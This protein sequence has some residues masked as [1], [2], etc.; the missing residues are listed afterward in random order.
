MVVA[1]LLTTLFAAFASCGWAAGAEYVEGEALVILKNSSGKRL[2]ARG[3]RGDAGFESTLRAVGRAGARTAH[4]YGDLSETA[5]EV[6]ALVRSETDSTE[7]LIEKLSGDPDV[8]SVTPNYI[9]HTKITPSDPLYTAGALWGLQKINAPTAWNITLGGG[10]V[11]VAVFDS[12]INMTHEDLLDNL[13]TKFSRSFVPGS[14]DGSDCSDRIGHGTHVSGIIAAAGDNGKGVAGVSWRA[15]LITIKIADNEGKSRVDTIVAALDYFLGILKD[16]PEMKIPAANFS[17]GF[18]VTSNPEISK[19]TVMY[20]AFKAISDT[21]RTVI[22]VAA[23]NEGVEVGVP[24]PEG[25][26]I[27][28]NPALPGTYMYP[29]SFTGIDNMVVVGAIDKDDNASV[30]RGGNGELLGATC[31][32]GAKV[33]ILA[34]GSDIVSAYIPNSNSYALKSGTSMATPHASGTIALMASVNPGLRASALKKIL[35]ESANENVNPSLS[36]PGLPQS[37][38]KISAHGLLDAGQALYA[39]SMTE[40]DPAPEAPAPKPDEGA[41]GIEPD[42]GASGVKPGNVPDEIAPNYGQ[43]GGG[44]GCDFGLGAAMALFSCA[45]LAI[46]RRRM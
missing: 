36:V 25:I 22:V 38:G 11:H 14:Y 46:G 26:Q 41:D 19:G 3:I 15:K 27:N 10:D 7:E 6:F 20:R 1:L 43:S 2:T 37:G 34:P 39:A 44:G 4:T 13:D 16:N 40:S 33:D 28:D 17:I 45:A 32:S 30:Y 23:G 18:Y 42:E 21:N 12:G 24:A 31:W 9:I 8:L 5:N 35:L 29:A